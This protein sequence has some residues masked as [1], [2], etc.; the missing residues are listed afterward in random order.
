MKSILTLFFSFSVFQLMT[1]SNA[2][3]RKDRELAS[4]EY[5]LLP[6]LGDLQTQKKGISFGYGKMFKS[7]YLKLGLGYTQYDLF[8]NESYY[9]NKLES[10]EN[11]YN[12][13]LDF[14]YMKPLKNNWSFGA[15]VSPAVSSTLQGSITKEDFIHNSFVSL[16]KRWFTNNLNSK[17]TFGVGY[18]TVFGS[19]RYFP[20]ISYSTQ[21]SKKSSYSIGLPI[22]G[23]FYKINERNSIDL[24][25]SL[26][27]SFANNPAPILNPQNQKINNSK[28]QFRG[29]KLGVGYHQ[30]FDKNWVAHF[31]LG[32]MP[33]NSIEITDK[34]SNI[35]YDVNTNHPFTLEQL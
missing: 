26:E 25:M 32:F 2:L 7:S 4:L 1:Q 5:T 21:L 3:S 35:I 16:N 15:S 6:D 17:L 11:L 13:R 10:F 19:P 33:N 34:D 31:G 30:K 20:L 12:I 28:I 23:Y 27:G 24:T 8:F 22:T 29:V 9:S 14:I 18:G